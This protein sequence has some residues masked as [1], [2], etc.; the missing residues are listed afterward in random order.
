[1]SLVCVLG[2]ALQGTEAGWVGHD[3]HKG[4]RGTYQHLIYT[5]LIL[6]RFTQGWGQKPERGTVGHKES[7][8]SRP[9]P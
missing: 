2:R 6:R 9:C 5:K 1:M 4:G 7:P 3:K 8:C